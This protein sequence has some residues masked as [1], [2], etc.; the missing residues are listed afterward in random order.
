MSECNSSID[1]WHYFKDKEKNVGIVVNIF[2]NGL[3]CDEEE[4]QVN[5]YTVKD[6]SVDWH[7]NMLELSEMEIR[8]VY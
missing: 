5:V 4:P 6:T 2:T 3:G 7:S 8:Y 1:N